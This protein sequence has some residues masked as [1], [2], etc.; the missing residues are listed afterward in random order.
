MIKTDR[1]EDSYKISEIDWM[2]KK[3]ELRTVE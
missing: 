2:R 3:K 1:R